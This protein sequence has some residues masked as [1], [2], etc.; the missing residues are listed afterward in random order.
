[1]AV[2]LPLVAVLVLT[3]QAAI[4]FLG[5][6]LWVAGRPGSTGTWPMTATVPSPTG[7]GAVIRGGTRTQGDVDSMRTP[8]PW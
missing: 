4:M 6:R 8:G 2:S 3:A 7:L 1:M 5:I